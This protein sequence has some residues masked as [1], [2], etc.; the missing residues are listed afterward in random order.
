M[1]SALCY[2]EEHLEARKW[3]MMHGKIRPHNQLF[4][5]HLLP[6]EML[7][8]TAAEAAAAEEAAAGAWFCIVAGRRWLRGSQFPAKPPHSSAGECVELEGL[9]WVDHPSCLSFYRYCP[10]PRDAGLIRGRHG[11]E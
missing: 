3:Q 2:A 7:M 5:P 4:I 8:L 1:S 11:V 6:P 10:S 9:M